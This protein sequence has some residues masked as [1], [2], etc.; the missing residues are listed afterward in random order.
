[1]VKALLAASTAAMMY[2]STYMERA[3]QLFRVTASG[4][5]VTEAATL[6]LPTAGLRSRGR[7]VWRHRPKGRLPSLD[8]R[9]KHDH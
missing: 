7:R 4:R 1:M 8:W 5:Y 9:P 3:A 2:Q 6:M